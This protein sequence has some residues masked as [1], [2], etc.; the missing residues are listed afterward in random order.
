ML[1]TEESQDSEMQHHR[2]G[3]GWMH[4]KG[5]CLI[6]KASGW[7]IHS[8]E[9]RW[10]TASP[11]VL[12][13]SH[14]KMAYWQTLLSWSTDNG[15]CQKFQLLWII[16]QKLPLP[17]DHKSGRHDLERLSWQVGSLLNSSLLLYTPRKL[18]L[19]PLLCHFHGDSFL[20]KKTI[21]VPML[22]ALWGP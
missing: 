15:S 8:R 5:D 7:T 21:S 4:F 13:P 3:L 19:D 20:I 9:G 14:L 16:F 6:I 17:Q 18:L 11:Q 2:Q 10:E 1:A 12:A 22:Q